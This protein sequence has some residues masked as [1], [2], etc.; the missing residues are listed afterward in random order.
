MP[1]PF[2]SKVS[3]WLTQLGVQT[4]MIFDQL[5]RQVAELRSSVLGEVV[6]L[7]GPQVPAGL[8]LAR[9]A[10]GQQV[11]RLLRTGTE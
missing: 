1:T 11:A 3:F 7:P 6:W 5:V 10:D 2:W 8:Y 4:V 9:S